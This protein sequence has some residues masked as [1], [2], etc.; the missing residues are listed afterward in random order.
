MQEN[1]Y[2]CLIILIYLIDPHGKL[3][4]DSCTLMM[5]LLVTTCG[6]NFNREPLA[7][8]IPEYSV[9]ACIFFPAKLLNKSL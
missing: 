5:A 9:G 4:L 8:C 3:L 7:M 6:A 1:A 2:I